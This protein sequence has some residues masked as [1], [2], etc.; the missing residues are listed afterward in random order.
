MNLRRAASAALVALALT[1]AVQA[2]DRVPPT[3]QALTGNVKPK[4][5]AVKPPKVKEPKSNGGVVV[6][7]VDPIVVADDDDGC[8]DDD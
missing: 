6:V 4:P 5:P 2:C 1:P 8:E 3:C 7:D